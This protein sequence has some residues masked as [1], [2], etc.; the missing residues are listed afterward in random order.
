MET[1]T[2]ANPI[3]DTNKRKVVQ[4]TSNADSTD[5]VEGHG[6]HV[7]GTALG[8]NGQPLNGNGQ[9]S[10]VAP[11]AKVA[12]MDFAKGENGLKVPPVPSLFSPGYSI[13]SKIW[14][15]SWGS[16]FSGSQYYTGSDYDTYLYQHPVTKYN[17]VSCVIR[18]NHIPE[19]KR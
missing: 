3:T 2:F 14:S 15:F 1:G 6:T 19:K 18:V 10:G 11:Y 13:G 4:Y 12:F 17:Y 5:A 8:N 16:Q 9:Y 7:C